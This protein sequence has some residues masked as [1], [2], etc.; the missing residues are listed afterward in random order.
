MYVITTQSSCL[1]SL[2]LRQCCSVI[3]I[4]KIPT[5]GCACVISTLYSDVLCLFNQIPFATVV[6]VTAGE[7]I[8]D[9]GVPSSVTVYSQ[10]LQYLL[11]ALSGKTDPCMHWY[12]Y[13]YLV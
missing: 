2:T 10:A 8:S 12:K 9:T 6:H 5:S 11:T 1:G 7:S 13:L 3:N 4:Q